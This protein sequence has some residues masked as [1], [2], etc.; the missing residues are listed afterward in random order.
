MVAGF[1]PVNTS[2]TVRVVQRPTGVVI[3]PAGMTPLGPDPTSPGDAP[4]G[5]SAVESASRA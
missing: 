3:G 5:M 1:R 2:P 4:S